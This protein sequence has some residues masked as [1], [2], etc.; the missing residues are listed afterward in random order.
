VTRKIITVA[1]SKGGIGK[2]TVALGI[3]KALA[4]RKI[5]TLIVDLDLGNASLDIFCGRED[6]ILYSL[7]DVAHSRCDAENA[8]FFLSE[9]F[10]LL[11]SPSG[12]SGAN[13]DNIEDYQIKDA[14]SRCA[15]AVNADCVVIDTGAGKNDAVK[16]AAEISNSAVVVAGHSPVSI[17]S[18]E[19]TALR[20]LSLGIENTRL[21]INSFDFENILRH[22]G[23]TGIFEIIDSSRVPLLGIVL[24]DYGI[25]LSQEFPDKALPCKTTLRAF[26][27]IAARICG[28]NVPLFDGIKELRKKRRKLFR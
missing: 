10:W 14:I 27:N 12:R 25:V 20:L 18:A 15:D 2:S 11:A 17:R 28:E 21:V 23:R 7:A 26:D 5:K 13:S 19:N 1:S 4:K 24:Y 3:A 9:N 6:S 8:V 16:T 22:R